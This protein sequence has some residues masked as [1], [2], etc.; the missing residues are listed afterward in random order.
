MQLGGL[1]A[2]WHAQTL[3]RRRPSSRRFDDVEA[4]EQLRVEPYHRTVD[5]A[6]AAAWSG[7]SAR[8]VEEMLDRRLCLVHGDFS[9]KNVLVG[10]D[11]ALW[12][13]DF[14]VAHVGDPAFDLG[15]ML[16]HLM[17]KAIHRPAAF[18]RYRA[19]RRRLLGCLPSAGQR[20]AGAGSHLRRPATRAASCSPA[21]TASLRPST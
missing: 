19:R 8:Y 1:L 9:P 21:S 18:E 13:I 14:E 16:N 12:L 11:D 5:A 2:A 15:F 17:L 10:E 4:F 20:S 6:L 3:A 7:R